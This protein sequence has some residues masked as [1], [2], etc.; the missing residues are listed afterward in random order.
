MD[1]II[2]REWMLLAA[3]FLMRASFAHP[4][5][6]VCR[7]PMR[8]LG[9]RCAVSDECKLPVRS[10]RCSWIPMS[11]FRCAKDADTQFLMRSF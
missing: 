4:V 5:S 1:C 2:V 7:F 3:Q 9:V 6:D 10:L 8:S 11:T